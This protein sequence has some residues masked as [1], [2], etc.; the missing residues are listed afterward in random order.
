M[1][2]DAPV[3]ADVASAAYTCSAALTCR[4]RDAG[5]YD[6]SAASI[7]AQLKDWIDNA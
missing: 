2:R 3:D 5:R 4:C 7:D 1:S 6:P